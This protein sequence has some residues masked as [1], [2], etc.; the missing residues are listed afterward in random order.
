MT[1]MARQSQPADLPFTI[2][3]VLLLLL[4]PAAKADIAA[5]RAALLSLRETV[6]GRTRLLWDPTQPDP[7]SWW[8]IHCL[9][10][11]VAHIR[12]PRGGL[13]GELPPHAFG[14]LTRLHTLSL[15]NNSISGQLPS[16]LG[17]CLELQV[18][19]L[20]N[21]Q[22]SGHLPTFLFG[23][24][25]LARL[26]LAR[27]S[28]SGEIPTEFNKLRRLK[29]LYLERNRLTGSIPDLPP[30]KKFNVS[31]NMLNGSIPES[32]QNFPA[33]AFYGNSLCG[34]PL[35]PCTG[36]GNK[37]YWVTVVQIV[38][39]AVISL[40]LLTTILCKKLRR[41]KAASAVGMLPPR[42]QP[43]VEIP[44]RK[45]IN[46]DRE[47]EGSGDEAVVGAAGHGGDK[48]L[49]V[50]GDGAVVESLRMEA[51]LEGPAEVLSR[52]AFGTSYKVE[53]VGGREMAVKRLRNVCVAE[54]EFRERVEELGKMVHGN[55]WPLRAYFY[56]RGEKLIVSDYAPAG[57][58]SSLLHGTAETQRAHLSW[59]TRSRIAAG[60][61]HG[62]EYLHMQ[63]ISHG[64]IKS[65]NV[66]FSSHS[67]SPHF[68]S[69]RKPHGCPHLSDY[70]ISQLASPDSAPTTLAY[71]APEVGDAF[72]VTQKADVY[73][74]G[75]LL[76]ELVTGKKPG[77]EGV[78][79]RKWV[80]FAGQG[81]WTVDP[82][83]FQYREYCEGQMVLVLRL[84]VACTSLDPERRPAMSEVRRQVEVICELRR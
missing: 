12:L 21:N 56:G 78:P 43:E 5:D 53:V 9:D 69:S 79:P 73:S 40:L 68:S 45:S 1:G 8:G 30:L 54:G 17:S 11:R 35:Q 32:L 20:Q 47:Y 14:N 81:K 63:G 26:D 59:E 51:L 82:Q 37:L 28:F 62:I 67:G 72:R 6:G 74:F 42:N 80:E 84:A 31:H 23:L 7:C 52:G 65:S 46:E 77:E 60:T 16:D 44:I 57:S 50:L 76:F 29:K 27:N 41:E 25:R 39:S 10:G 71:C 4:L 3:T 33:D 24:S 2:T 75:V 15:R 18:L 38:V 66:L 55:L 13:E 22:L 64:N 34:A 49:R 61:A 19:D 48:K 36:R 70:G 58:L 83:L